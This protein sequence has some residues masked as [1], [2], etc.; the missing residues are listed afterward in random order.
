MEYLLTCMQGHDAMKPYHCVSFRVIST[1]AN[2]L[3]LKPLKSFEG[4]EDIENPS[5]TLEID[6]LYDRL[7]GDF[8]MYKQEEL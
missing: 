7:K 1:I 3:M 8:L 2:T 4:I 6:Q 5:N